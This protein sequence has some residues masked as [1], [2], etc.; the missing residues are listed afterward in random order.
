M[1]MTPKAALVAAL[2]VS[3]GA[4]SAQP[5][6]FK[7]PVPQVAPAL[8][9]IAMTEFVSD[10]AT[11]PPGTTQV[12]LKITV[13]NLTGG[14]QAVTLNG[15]KIRMLRTNP[16]PD[17]LELETT[18]VNLAPG[19][20]QSVSQTVNVA[21]GVREYFARVDP[22]D[23][24]HEPILQ[25]ANNEK[26]LRINIPQLVAAQAAAAPAKETQLLDFD[27]AKRSGAQFGGSPNGPVCEMLVVDAN[28][29]DLSSAPGRPAAGVF[30]NLRCAASPVGARSDPEAFTS[31]RLKNGWKVK[32]FDV[33][34]VQRRVWPGDRPAGEQ[35]ANWQWT[36][37]PSVATDDPSA[38]LH[39]WTNANRWITLFVKVEIE[40]PAGTNP[41][42]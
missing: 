7:P 29:P 14:P 12:K 16:Q 6:E 2:L 20:T 35:D 32:S 1:H 13:K 28:T 40:G 27:K 36:K 37:T 8:D 22:D 5:R 23:T 41:Y 31:F 38:K 34:G 11:I 30:F 19:A 10:P 3:A 39:L 24:L 4:A 15:L 33:T 18:V 9:K 42:Q 17:V 21:A 25:R 26:R